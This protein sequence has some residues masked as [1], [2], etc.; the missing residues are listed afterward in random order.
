[1]NDRMTASVLHAIHDV[2]LE[3][4]EIPTLD[5]DQVLV[6]IA[7]V[8]VCGS[9]VHYFEHG[10]IGDFIVDAPMVLGHEASGR[11][12]RVGSAV[13]PSRI[14]ERV[15]IEPQRSCRR[16]EQCKHGRY[17]LCPSIEF[18]ATPPIDGSF[19]GYAA[20]QEDFAHTIPDNVSFESAALCEPLSVGIWTNQ[21]AEV[22]PGSSILIAGAGPIGIV[23]AQTA[24]AFGASRIVVSDPA[25]ERRELA[26]RFGAT[27]V[28]DPLSGALGIEPVDVF[29]DASG[30][31]RAIRDGIL[32][33]KRAGRAVLVG[34]GAPDV[35]LPVGRIQN[36]EI[37]VTGVFRYANTWPLAI[38]MIAR[39]VV[40]LDSMVTGRFDLEHVEEAL[41]S[42]ADPRTVKSLVVPGSL[43]D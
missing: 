11:I 27:D 15:S 16:C 25:P 6:E 2:R 43:L 12:A 14:G 23:I 35:E 3:Q 19:A 29:V 21:K 1:M 4:I 24:R 13:D 18:Y 40:D 39:G 36:Y 20:I 26:A 34:M 28:V 8:G 5:P 42:T 37:L 32:L 38:D 33:V 30:N 22:G 31:P 9:D 7:A 41:A 17:N 10:R